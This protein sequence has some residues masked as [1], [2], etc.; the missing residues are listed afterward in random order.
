MESYKGHVLNCAQSLEADYW[1]PCCDQVEHLGIEEF[2]DGSFAVNHSNKGSKLKRASNFLKRFRC[3]DCIS[4]LNRL[5]RRHVDSMEGRAELENLAVYP[6]GKAEMDSNHD[7]RTSFES[8]MAIKTPPYPESP[9]SIGFY[10]LGPSCHEMDSKSP[11]IEKVKDSDSKHMDRESRIGPQHSN[12]DRPLEDH[13]TLYRQEQ[14]RISNA[15]M[16]KSST[17]G[18][19]QPSSSLVESGGSLPL[20]SDSGLL[21][22]ARRAPPDDGAVSSLS[23]KPLQHGI[24]IKQDLASAMTHGLPSWPDNVQHSRT[25]QHVNATF[26]QGYDDIAARNTTKQRI[27]KM[28]TTSTDKNSSNL[29]S[30]PP[31]DSS[32]PSYQNCQ[33][34]SEQHGSDNAPEQPC[35][36]VHQLP[37]PTY[38]LTP[39]PGVAGSFHH[40]QREILLILRIEIEGEAFDHPG[41]Q[42]LEVQVPSTRAEAKYLHSLMHKFKSHWKRYSDGCSESSS[43]LPGLNTSFLLHDGL[44]VLAQ[45]FSGNPP[46]TFRGV[47]ALVQFAHVCASTC[48]HEKSLSAQSPF[49]RNALR[50]GEKITDWQDRCRFCKL[51]YLLWQ[52]QLQS[53]DGHYMDHTS[54]LEN[55]LAS[56]AVISSCVRFL[57]GKVW[58]LTASYQC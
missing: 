42:M 58:Y 28:A 5:R 17:N 19:I 33:K 29:A 10:E 20:K 2:R 11:T 46:T 47:F 38:P 32:C 18:S 9:D 25:K 53:N 54:D 44:E 35:T 51:A 30:L 4:Y 45:Y 12:P 14:S 57:D 56:G 3:P 40:D 39:E 23:P 15:R 48:P 41:Q 55:S 22:R 34:G 37:L 24:Q 27:P 49:F 1:C 31:S 7:T 6:H 16:S 8:S 36:A 52:G 13:S 50:W 43:L 26:H 21:T